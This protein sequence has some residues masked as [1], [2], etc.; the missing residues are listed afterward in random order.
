METKQDWD[1]WQGDA[2]STFMQPKID[3]EIY[4]VPTAA[5]RHFSQELRDMEAVHG[6]GP[7]QGKVVAP[8]GRACPAF[9]TARGCGMC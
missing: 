5:C 8:C 6:Q 1:D 4:L 7:G 9:R 2:P 3:T